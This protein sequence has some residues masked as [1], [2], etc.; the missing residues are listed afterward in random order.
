MKLQQLE[1]KSSCEKC[2]FATY[3]NNKQT[4]CNAGRLEKLKTNSHICD[5]GDKSWY[6]LKRFC[7]LYRE[8]DISIQ[9]A[10]KQIELKFAIIIYDYNDAAYLTAMESIK[11]IDYDKS[12]F[13]AIFS[14][15]HNKNASA[16]FNIINN[17]KHEKINAELIVDLLEHDKDYNAFSRG[18]GASYFIKS[19]SSIEIP[20]DL[21]SRIDKSINDDL[22]QIIMFE[23]Q[24]DDK[25]ITCLPF[26]L[27]NKEYTNYNDYGLMTESIKDKLIKT[28]T[29]KSL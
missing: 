10:R 22:E 1:Y 25:T 24:V 16:L 14:S 28:N 5:S 7:N 26:W 19:D 6:L 3:E 17:L 21:L 29:Y 27:V 4:G 18:V 11:N 8:Q 15:K 23:K 2:I 20:S 12:K 9:E 13:K